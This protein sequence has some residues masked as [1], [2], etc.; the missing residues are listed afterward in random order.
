M[1]DI[2]QRD[3]QQ[4]NTASGNNKPTDMPDFFQDMNSV[5]EFDFTSL[6]GN[7]RGPG[8]TY[9]VI[10]LTEDENGGY[11]SMV[12]TPYSSLGM[13]TAML[14]LQD[15]PSHHQVSQLR[16][17]LDIQRPHSAP[18]SPRLRSNPYLSDSAPGS[19][20]MNQSSQS[21]NQTTRSLTNAQRAALASLNLNGSGKTSPN[22]SNSPSLESLGA[23]LG[24]DTSQMSPEELRSL[25]TQMQSVSA[26]TAAEIRRQMHIQCE[27]KRRSQI[28]YGFE[29]LKAHLPGFKHKKL[30]KAMILQ[31]SI[32]FIGQIKREHQ[33][34]IQ[35]MEILRA[36]NARLMSM[37]SLHQP[38]Q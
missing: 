10:A 21:Q 19:P 25:A 17:G 24:I 31:K 36:E 7:Q 16:A 34:M 12:S 23:S 8:D 4:T 3:Q 2:Q 14:E 18:T 32:E 9:E 6:M 35:E 30:S 20:M 22:G 1:T 38:Q 15:F 27:Q 26:G 11:S 37:M 33:M 29:E 5:Q 28:K 13:P